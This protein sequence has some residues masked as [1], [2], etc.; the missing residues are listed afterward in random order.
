MTGAVKYAKMTKRGSYVKP[1]RSSA[2]SST[3]GASTERIVGR[4]GPL[5]GGTLNGR[6]PEFAEPFMGGILNWADP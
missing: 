3:S 2:E 1:T 5:M 4:V 6:N